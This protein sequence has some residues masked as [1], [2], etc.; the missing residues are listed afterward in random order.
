MGTDP[1]TEQEAI[2]M[3]R[4]QNRK[5]QELV[6]E[7]ERRDTTI[8]NLQ[9]QL[10]SSDNYR[11]QMENYKRQLSILE[12]KIHLYETDY[13]SKSTFLSEQLKHVSEAETK[14]R[15]QIIN[16]DKIIHE[17]DQVIKD[18]E[19]QI[20]IY[21]KQI[22]DKDGVYSELKQ[23]FN[24]IT[25][26]FK[27][28]TL[29]L[30]LKEEEYRK[31]KDDQEIKISDLIREKSLLE[32]K[33][34]QLIDIVKQYS[35][36]LSEY[37][38]Q[39][40]A[41]ETEKRSLQK[42]NS[43]MNEEIE[44]S[45]K[46]N[47]ELQNDL[48]NLKKLHTN[49][50]EAENVINNLQNIYDNEKMKNEN[51]IRT[52]EDLNKK[53]QYLKE[54][55]SGENSLENL[56][57]TISNLEKELSNTNNNYDNLIKSN[58]H[59]EN[60]IMNLEN[61]NK[62]VNFA[63]N[64]EIKSIVQ[65][66]ETY[67]GVFY[68][69]HFEIP[70]LPV[71]ISK[72]IKNKFKIDILKD[73][74]KKSRKQINEELNK[75]ENA[76]KEFKKEVNDNMIKQEKLHR[77]VSELKN[78]ILDKNEEIYSLSSQLES[79]EN[80]LI[81]NK[82]DLNRIKND[83]SI[84]QD[85]NNRFLDK[86]Y[87]ITQK[88]IED[89]LKNERFKNFYDFVYR[90]NYSENLKSQVEDNIDKIIQ[91]INHATT[92]LQMADDKM[93]ELNNLKNENEKLKRELNDTVKSYKEEMEKSFRDKEEV[94]RKF[95]RSQMED[96]RSNESNLKQ[97]IEKLKL[98]LNEKDDII[99]QISQENNLLKSQIDLM[100]K[101]VS[102]NKY[103]NEYKEKFEKLSENCKS[104]EKKCR[105]LS[106]EIDLKDMQ[107]KNQEQMITRR[108]QE[109]NDLKSKISASGGAANLDNFDKEKIKALEVSFEKFFNMNPRNILKKGLINK[110]YYSVP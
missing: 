59:N 51:L 55:H 32:E 64:N 44:D 50:V 29:K 88:Q 106:T 30:G 39:V 101:N 45:S 102:N 4:T 62:E 71:T 42:V 21:K 103:D 41:L 25:A 89:V 69:Q 91:I 107:I 56:R 95:E 18:Q 54:K 16:K 27:N 105:N 12:E 67:L 49:L 77:E 63:V 65:W 87:Q 6:E 60:K 20:S 36:E 17:Y 22:L 26:K 37:S 97:A 104:L 15:N 85:H 75:Y 38:V 58:T 7:L 8:Q 61:E 110:N 52:N 33:L 82:D 11:I 74:L 86:I 28:L 94:L 76:I 83:V 109:I 93:L 48:N 73:V 99:S 53:L 43:R 46:L 84:K 24:E 23:D 100:E 19:K 79:Y 31:I 5:I 96:V 47:M 72:P 68:E 92:Q 81:Q 35:K 34:N 10:N 2:N 1:D 40:Q 80:S 3:I 14:L 98:R 108:T 13:S 90:S 70:D 9:F 78:Q 66:A 57:M